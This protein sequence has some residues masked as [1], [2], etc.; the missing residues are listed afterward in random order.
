MHPLPSAATGRRNALAPATLR[1][2]QRRGAMAQPRLR[3]DHFGWSKARPGP[4]VSDIRDG[5]CVGWA[6]RSE[7][8]HLSDPKSNWWARRFAP[9]PT[10]RPYYWK[11]RVAGEAGRMGLMC[12]STRLASLATA[13]AARYPIHVLSLP[14]SAF[15]GLTCMSR[16]M[17]EFSSPHVVQ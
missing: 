1:A 9:L 5:Q 15:F 2:E 12:A 17:N 11:G 8:H 13:P 6:E 7:A 16:H 10:L 14:D 4:G 3:G